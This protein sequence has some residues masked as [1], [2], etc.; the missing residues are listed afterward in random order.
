MRHI[1]ASLLVIGAGAAAALAVRAR[2][3]PP[4]GAPRGELARAPEPGGTPV[5]EYLEAFERARLFGGTRTDEQGA[6]P[7]AAC[8]LPIEVLDVVLVHGA[9]EYSVATV[10]AGGRVDAVQ[11]GDLVGGATVLEVGAIRD[12]DG[13]V[14]AGS[15]ELFHEGARMRCAGG[16]AMTTTIAKG[17]PGVE[18][19]AVIA[20]EQIDD[21]ARV[22]MTRVRAVP[23]FENGKISGW[24]IA[25]LANTL[26][27]TIGFENGDVVRRVNGYEI[28]GP[29]RALQL[30]AMLRNERDVTVDYERR[31]E[32]TTLQVRVQ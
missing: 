9:P 24:R 13:F 8:R 28:D 15:I 26:L 17:P 21:A 11:A 6:P 32:P 7:P 19:V 4:P 16:S 31:G 29:E 2:V 12:A 20:R 25:N 22:A 23:V 10:R 27:A 14:I 30:F 5:E 3:E 1:A 18:R